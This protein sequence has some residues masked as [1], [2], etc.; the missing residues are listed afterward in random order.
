MELFGW[1][2]SVNA[3][4]SGSLKAFPKSSLNKQGLGSIH[5]SHYSSNGYYRAILSVIIRKQQGTETCVSFTDLSHDIV[6]L[7]LS[8]SLSPSLSLPLSLYL[9]LRP[10]AGYGLLVQEAFRDHTLRCATVG[11]TPLDEWS[12]SM[13]RVFVTF[14]IT[15][16]IINLLNTS[17]QFA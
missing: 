17:W 3:K 15:I 7:S 10:N 8:L 11:R 1:S 12:T 6:S 9:A 14:R 16:F 13:Q 2:L 4:K 5:C